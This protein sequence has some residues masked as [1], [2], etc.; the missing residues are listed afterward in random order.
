MRQEDACVLK[1][2]SHWATDLVLSEALGSTRTLGFRQ[3]MKECSSSKTALGSNFTK[4][5]FC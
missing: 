1:T 3:V 5:R 4:Q 2:V